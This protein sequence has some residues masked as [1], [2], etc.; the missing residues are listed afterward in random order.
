MTEKKIFSYKRVG[1]ITSIILLFVFTGCSQRNSVAYDA[2]NANKINRVIVGK[3][4]NIRGVYIKDDGKGSTIG[5]IIGGIAGSTIGK[6][7]GST[8]AGL[9]GAILGGVIGSKINK[10]NAQELT[11]S[12]QN[13]ETIVV[14]SKGTHLQ[15]GD[16]VRIV[17]VNDNVSTVYKI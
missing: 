9:G 7:D 8:L 2:E 17:K 5:A 3:I 10:N 12:L 13:G 11:V 4:I 15:V 16:S 1:L 6:G 14:L